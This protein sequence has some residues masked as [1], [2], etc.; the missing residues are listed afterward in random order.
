MIF[1]AQEQSVP[2]TLLGR[3]RHLDTV[4]FRSSHNRLPFL[5]SDTNCFSYGHLHWCAS[6]QSRSVSLRLAFAQTLC[7]HL[8]K[9]LTPSHAS[10]FAP[11][12][13]LGS[14]LT[15]CPSKG[16]GKVII[17][18]EL[19]T[20][21]PC[22]TGSLSRELARKAEMYVIRGQVSGVAALTGLCHW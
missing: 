22:P 18:G 15:N 2:I 9:R 14:W 6:C 11:W 20:V 13:M 4:V 21:K 12:A 16:G 7:A 3:R 5:A 10:S 1:K 8:I 17:K 19:W